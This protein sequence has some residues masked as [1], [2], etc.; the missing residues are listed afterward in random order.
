MKKVIFVYGFMNSNKDSQTA[1]KVLD[2]YNVICFEYD[3]GLK[4]PIEEIAKKLDDFIFS[5]TKK[6]EKVNLIGVSAGGIIA[7]YYTKFISPN[8]VDKLATICSPFNGTYVPGFYTKKREGL[9]EL[10]YNSSFLKKLNSKKL[11]KEKIINIYSFFDY[12]V[13]GNSGKGE[14]PVHT[15]NFIHFTASWDKRILNNIKEFFSH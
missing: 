1:R 6:D 4:Q 2:N 13:P 12:L 8:K 9:K 7:A 11:D 14:N 15:W 5:K 3:S 10:K